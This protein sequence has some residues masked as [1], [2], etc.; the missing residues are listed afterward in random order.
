MKNE[1]TFT[2]MAELNNR[3]ISALMLSM[4]WKDFLLVKK[5]IIVNSCRSNIDLV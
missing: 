5:L 2:L 4:Q 3:L 1:N